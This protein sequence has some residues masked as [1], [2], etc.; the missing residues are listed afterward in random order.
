MAQVS[1]GLEQYAS[2]I[3]VRHLACIDEIAHT[4]TD[5]SNAEFG[6]HRHGRGG[7]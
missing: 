5:L 1:S 2:E 6:L 7:D 4:L 3:E